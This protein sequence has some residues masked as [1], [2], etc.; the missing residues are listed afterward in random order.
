MESIVEAIAPELEQLAPD[1]QA[2]RK[3]SLYRIY[4]DT[5]F[6]NDKTLQNTCC[7]RFPPSDSQHQGACF[8]FLLLER[9][10]S[11]AVCTVRNRRTFWQCGTRS[12]N[13][14]GSSNPL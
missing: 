6:S 14:T 8:Y 7:S 4:R 11:A 2:S 12:L 13:D 1:L 3:T 10:S 5:R 9:A